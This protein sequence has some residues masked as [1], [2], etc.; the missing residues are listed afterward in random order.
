MAKF[1]SRMAGST[2]EKEMLLQVIVESVETRKNPTEYSK[3]QF[4]LKRGDK[5]DTENTDVTIPA[6]D[7]FTVVRKIFNKSSKFFIVKDTNA[8][9]EK[10]ATLVLFGTDPKGKQVNL[11]EKEFNVAPFGG[12]VR[13]PTSLVLA[14]TLT[15]S[16]LPNNKVNLRVT[17]LPEAEYGLKG[18]SMTEAPAVE[19]PQE[20]IPKPPVEEVKE[21][22]PSP[23]EIHENLKKE[24]ELL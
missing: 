15:G 21:Q 22:P 24:L 12:K 13:E 6:G 9:Q 3:L 19:I 8:F 16:L 17:I 14:A 11:G 1:L 10:S 2:I 7:S 4:V 23:V 18:I 5:K 20:W